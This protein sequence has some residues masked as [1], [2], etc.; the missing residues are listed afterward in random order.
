MRRVDVEKNATEEF[1]KDLKATTYEIHLGIAVELPTRT[2]P[3][4]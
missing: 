2:I 1:K 4:Y 3:T